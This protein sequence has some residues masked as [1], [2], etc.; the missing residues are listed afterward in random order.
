MPKIAVVQAGTVLFDKKATFEKV[1]KYVEEAAKNK[2][3]LVLFPE[4]F[5]GGY[6]KWN[7][8]GIVMGTRTMEGREEF[9]RY[10][11]NA[12]EEYGE[13]NDFLTILSCK[14]NIHLVIGVVEKEGGT[15]YCSVFFF[16]PTHGYLGKHRK[17]MPTAL[18]RCVWGQGDGSTMKVHNTPVGRIGAGICWENYMP[19]FRVHMYNQQIE[20]YLAPTV[21]DR[22][23]WLSTMRTIAL[24]GRCFVVSACQFLTSS[25]Y[26][27]NHKL[28][29]EHGE[30]KIMIRGGSCAIDPLG[31]VLIEPDFSQETIRFTDI[32]LA[33][34]PLGKM[35]LDVCGHYSRPDVFQLIVDEQPK[36]NVV[37][38]Q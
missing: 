2:A 10:F 33:E 31:N 14:Y 5:I 23:V 35:D 3:D 28:R 21:D 24:E 32:D 30:Q 8:F 13:D 27:A 1:E 11:E 22:D 19:L 36:L 18:E 26:P 38:K 4:A 15:L 37:R 9:K 16:S 17:L 25:D 29:L 12:I 34:I 7:D 6:P 20:I